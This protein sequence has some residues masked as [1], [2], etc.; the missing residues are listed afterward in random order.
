MVTPTAGLVYVLISLLAGTAAGAGSEFNRVRSIDAAAVELPS[1]A[2]AR[3][4]G[5]VGD[6]DTAARARFAPTDTD[7]VPAL[8]SPVTVRA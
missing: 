2:N 8:R 7:T 4:T 1:E 6:P 3:V 5:N